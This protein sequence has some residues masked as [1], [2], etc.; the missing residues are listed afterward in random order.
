[1]LLALV[2]AV[3]SCSGPDTDA[4]RGGGG[5]QASAPLPSGFI[6]EDSRVAGWS[7]ALVAAGLKEGST[8]VIGGD[9]VF[10]WGGYPDLS[11]VMT[12]DGLIVDV[13]SGEVVDVPSA[14]IEARHLAAG[15]WTGS[16]FVLIGGSSFESS[17][18]DGAA[19]DPETGVWREL[20]AFPGGS[21]SQATA[22]W[23][24][25]QLY[26]WAPDG[27]VALGQ[28]PSP[29]SG[30]IAA[31]DAEADEW[32]PL[33]PLPFEAIGGAL[34]EDPGGIRFVGGPLMRSVGKEGPELL[35]ATA[36]LDPTSGEWSTPAF[37]PSAESARVIAVEGGAVRVLLSDGSIYR[38]Q[39]GRL[40][41]STKLPESC[42]WAI[43][44]IANGAH[45]YVQACSVFALGAD[46]HQ[47]ILQQG[48]AG[49]PAGSFR[50]AFLASADG[51][52]IVLRPT[53]EGDTTVLG[54]YQP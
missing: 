15:V 41:E 7:F 37:G 34:V 43:E 3:V 53:E 38:L 31:Y 33:P 48:V 12:N 23:I 21:A 46:H 18:G 28:L 8:Y 39:D 42:P 10:A 6:G 52:L 54:I 2:L 44:G 26:V 29:G 5:S 14:P 22:V 30:T 35:V 51:A 11:G 13:R 16:E 27:A 47:L 36:V 17:F 40:V 20:A 49:T 19:Y 45:G 4:T 25:E 9:L 24:G 50:S 1:M 32:R